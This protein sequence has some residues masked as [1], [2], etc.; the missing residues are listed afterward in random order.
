MRPKTKALAGWLRKHLLALR[1]EGLNSRPSTTMVCEQSPS[2]GDHGN[3]FGET[4][5]AVDRHL[6]MCKGLTALLF[7]RTVRMQGDNAVSR[8][9]A[10]AAA[11]RR[12]DGVFGNLAFVAAPKA[13][14][15]AAA[16][17]W[18]W[19]RRLRPRRAQALRRLPF[20]RS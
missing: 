2:D 14:T 11:A 3:A 4:F 7:A 19:Q 12:Q 13:A 1:V 15:I 18:R 9:A 20:V 5:V 16:T 10:P 8:G 17:R 6:S